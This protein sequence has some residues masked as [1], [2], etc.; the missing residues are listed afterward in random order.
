MWGSFA[1]FRQKWCRCWLL[2]ISSVYGILVD[3][4]GCSCC[5]PGQAVLSGV[6]RLGDC[7]SS[8][9]CGKKDEE[10]LGPDAVVSVVPTGRETGSSASR[11]G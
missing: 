1:E 4:A 6:V 10:D 2:S 11:S 5:S 8:A 3:C 9:R 7:V